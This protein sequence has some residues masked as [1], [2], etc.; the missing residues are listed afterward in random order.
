VEIDSEVA[1]ALATEF[2]FRIETPARCDQDN[3]IE[4]Q[5]PFVKYFFPATKI[6]PLGL[7]PRKG[8]LDIAR[9]VVEIA[10]KKGRVPMVLGSTD[11]TH[12]GANYGYLPK[13]GGKEAV[14]WVKDINDKRIV[15]LMVR[16]DAEGLIAESLANYNACCAGA[17]AA[18]I[19]ACRILGATRAEKVD[20]YTSYDIRPDASFVGYA[21]V[22]FMA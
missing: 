19:T 16:M 9:R 3:T 17:A 20:Y 6:V 21:G 18:A 1:G 8:S 11:L 4:L 12:Y 5:L 13:G 10:E 2:H 15:D 22:I 14:S 7:P